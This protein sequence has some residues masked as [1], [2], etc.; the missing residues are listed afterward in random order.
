[1]FYLKMYDH[2]LNVIFILNFININV[3]SVEILLI[4]IIFHNE[5]F[6]L[7]SADIYL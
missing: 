7:I 3:F 6:S 4:L 1:M 2:F 5:Y